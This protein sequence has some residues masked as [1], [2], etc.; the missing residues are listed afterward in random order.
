MAE[1]GGTTNPKEL[2]PGSPEALETTAQYLHAY[3]DTLVQAGEGLKRIDTEAGWR[4]KAGDAFRERFDGEPKRWIEAGENFRDA[5][6][7]L[8]EY[9]VVLRSAQQ[10]AKTAIDQY[11]RGQQAT[12][13]A[14][15]QHEQQVREAQASGNP[16]EVPFNDPGEADRKA[17]QRLLGSARAS[18]ET[19]G[20]TAAGKVRKATEAAPEEP[21][22]WSEVGDFLGDVG[23]ALVEGGAEVI[24]A[25]V[26]YGNA[27]VEHPE[28]A[29][30]LL[31]GLLLAGV[32]LGGEG[33]GVVLDA[34]G[35]GAVAGVPLNAVSAAGVTAGVG[36]AG[37]GATN[38]AQHAANDSRVEPLKMNSQSSGSGGTSQRPASELIKNGQEYKGTGKGRHKNNLPSTNGPPN[39]T[40]YKK[41]PNTGQVTN[42][43]TY[44]ANGNA[45]K[46][47]DLTGKPHGGVDTPHVVE[48]QH[49]VNPHTG[50]VFVRESK[51]VRAAFPWEIP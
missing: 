27:M 31:G 43:T 5:A 33:L 44:D 46:R 12:E 41:D 17:A 7:A 14:K 40:L 42:Y 4:G 38:L 35:V 3:G 49:N 47:V 48:Y 1:L 13:N 51:K 24:N 25:I 10:K 30:T 2:V 32:S 36:I 18:V 8:R 34:T 39:G 11:A 20:N 29:A 21:G 23:E 22:F 28:D 16:T 26:S 6:K 19:A 45:I 15:R 50:E 9:I 37:V